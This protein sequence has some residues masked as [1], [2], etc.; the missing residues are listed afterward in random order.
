LAA[1]FALAPEL[2]FWLSALAVFYT[3]VGYP[4]LITV[5]ARLRSRPVRTAPVVPSISMIIPAY[6]EESVIARKLD[7]SL[8]LDY[9]PAQLEIVVISDG[10]TDQTNQIVKGYGE[11]G[12]RLLF[13]APRRGKTAALNR[14]VPLTKGDILVFTDANAMLVPQTLRHL[15]RNFA[16]E[17]VACVGGEKRVRSD[18][19]PSGWGES[20]YWR[21]ESHLK[22]CDSAVGSVMGVAGEILAVR[23]D[24]YVPVEENSV[25]EDFVLSLGLVQAGWRVI[26]EPEA[27]AW[28]QS[29]PSLAAEWQRRTRIAAG[30]FQSIVRLRGM[31]NPQL[32]LPAF[33]Y[34]S[35]RVLRWFA[36]FFLI[37]LFLTNIRLRSRSFYDRTLFAQVLFY[38]MASVG[39]LL[40]QVGVFLRPLQLVFY[41]CF[42]NLA[43][44]VGFIRY[45][46]R[47]QPVTWK[48]T[49]P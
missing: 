16:D 45:I 24:C 31:L 34:I 15:V 22:R 10:S 23:R 5:L 29:T 7:N 41:F 44:L 11:Q 19:S 13:E 30:G 38:A 46:T 49:R 33:Q 17:H 8:A 37:V 4:I 2:L 26:Y 42:T 48:K 18:E 39:F 25:I 6:D 12:A 35:H 36:P 40:G 9:P 32:G 47:S 14:A 27:I 21:Y 28:E 20:A 43:A 1:S 3:Y